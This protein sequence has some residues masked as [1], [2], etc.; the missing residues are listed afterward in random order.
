MSEFAEMMLDGTLCEG[1]GEY[2]GEAGGYAARC[3]S[4]SRSD[5]VNE[6]LYPP[7]KH[8]KV[9]CPTCGKRVKAAGLDMHN[10]DKHGEQS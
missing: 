8:G 6:K 3:A 7:L 10:Q 4:C 5:G 9:A 1:C 2:L